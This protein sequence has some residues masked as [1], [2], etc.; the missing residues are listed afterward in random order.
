MTSEQ[1][2]AFQAGSS[3][4]P[5]EVNVMVLGLLCA[6]LFVW[7]AWV[8]LRSWQAYSGN[9]LT[10]RQFGGIAARTTLLLLVCFW[11]VLS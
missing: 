9:A 3:A 8:L 7:A 1:I 11:L 4:Q 10:L 2:T 5:A 6:A